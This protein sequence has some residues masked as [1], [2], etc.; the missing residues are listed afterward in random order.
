MERRCRI[1]NFLWKTHC[2][3]FQFFVTRT[4]EQNILAYY[5][6]AHNEKLICIATVG[7]SALL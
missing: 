6:N 2:S 5:N 1:T 7:R 3:C 4:N